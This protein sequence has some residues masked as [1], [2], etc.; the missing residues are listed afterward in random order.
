[1]YLVSKS[2]SFTYRVLYITIYLYRKHT[3]ISN[4]GIRYI[5]LLL[6]DYFVVVCVDFHLNNSI[7][8]YRYFVYNYFIFQ[9]NMTKNVNTEPDVEMWEPPELN[10]K[11]SS[12]NWQRSPRILRRSIGISITFTLSTNIQCTSQST[13]E[14]FQTPTTGAL[15]WAMHAH[16]SGLPAPTFTS[17][18]CLGRVIVIFILFQNRAEEDMHYLSLSRGSFLDYCVRSDHSGYVYS[19]A[20]VI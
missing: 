13:R 7:Q 20:E 18:S 15:L 19:I 11:N 6:Y 10:T 2:Y 9:L 3:D 8:G 17:T 4:R 1:M 16:S 12:V 5:L 14:M